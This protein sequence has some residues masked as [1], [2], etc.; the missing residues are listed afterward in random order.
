MQPT[1]VSCAQ[2]HVQH[3]L[4]LLFRIAKL[5]HLVTEHALN[6]TLLVPQLDRVH[7]VIAHSACDLVAPIRR[8]LDLTFLAVVQQV[9]SVAYACL[10]CQHCCDQS[11][12]GCTPKMSIAAGI[13]YGLL[14]RVPTLE[15]P[16]DAEQMLLSSVRLYHVV[17]KVSA[18]AHARPFASPFPTA[19]T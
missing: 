9:V 18:L 7:G 12:K 6:E 16:T 15:T 10:L 3:F 11:A 14:S 2:R 19:L 4:L 8:R 13:D 1:D 17:V 5:E